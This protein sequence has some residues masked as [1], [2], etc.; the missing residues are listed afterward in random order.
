[1]PSHFGNPSQSSSTNF[2]SPNFS[3]SVWSLAFRAMAR[4]CAR[5]NRIFRSATTG[6]WSSPQQRDAHSARCLRHWESPLIYRKCGCLA[7][8]VFVMQYADR[9]SRALCPPEGFFYGG[10]FC[11]NDAWLLP[12]K[13][14]SHKLRLM[15]LCFSN[16]IDRPPFP[17]LKQILRTYSVYASSFNTKFEMATP[18]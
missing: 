4:K 12:S 11:Q 14:D 2:G 13:C 15:V 7:L 9:V 1:M 10:N 3:I 6:G 16:K 18:P 8:V 17:Y 5:K